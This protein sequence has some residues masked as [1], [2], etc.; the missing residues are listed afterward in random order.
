MNIP[1]SHEVDDRFGTH[2]HSP[3][4]THDRRRPPRLL[5]LLE[6]CGRS[7]LNCLSLTSKRVRVHVLRGFKVHRL[8]EL[9]AS[10]LITL[11]GPEPPG[12]LRRSGAARYKQLGGCPDDPLSRSFTILGVF[13]ILLTPV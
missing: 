3:T 4:L 9:L 11:A 7:G 8:T 6:H 5:G 10:E 13:P 2:R 12:G 1:R